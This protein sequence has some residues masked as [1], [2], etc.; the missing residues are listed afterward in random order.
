MQ[1][2]KMGLVKKA[3]AEVFLLPLPF[4]QT[5]GTLINDYHLTN[6]WDC[7]PGG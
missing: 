2:P 5:A 6:A 4:Q 7:R 3:G 1:P